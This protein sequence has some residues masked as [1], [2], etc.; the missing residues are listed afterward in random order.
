[1]TKQLRQRRPHSGLGFLPPRMRMR[2]IA[3]VFA[4]VA[5]LSQGGLALAHAEI[6]VGDGRYVMV[7][8]FRDEP[9]FVGQAN[10]LSVRVEEFATGGARPVDGL[11]E[12]LTA[13]VSRDGQV[14]SLPLVPRGDGTYEGIFVPT[15]PGDY[16]FHI[17]G[18]I[19]DAT[20]DETITSGP[21]TFNAVEP[22]S[23]IEFPVQSP[24]PGQLMAQA[25]AANATADLAR[26]L[27]IAGL[28][29]GL[30]GLVVGAV[31]LTRARRPRSETV[32]APLEPTG[33]LIR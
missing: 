18:T 4:A 19:G 13:E 28:V 3:L 22:L 26:T 15:A 16:T 14:R 25:T 31:A 17:A 30:L 24:D 8:G 12:T 1:M 27:G 11:A 20:V 32:A 21:D 2:V 10:A 29:A 9:A 6:D 33:K 23:S 7:I 5:A